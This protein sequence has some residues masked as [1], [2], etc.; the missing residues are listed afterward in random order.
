MRH[1]AAIEGD[2]A[3]MVAKA[4]IHCH[5]EG[6]VPPALA[7]EQAKRYGVSLDDIIVDGAYQWR[8]FTEF[9]G[10]YDRVAALFRTRED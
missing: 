7:L 3:I 4:E 2:T 1:D 6:A 8:D 5:I 9:L 10:C